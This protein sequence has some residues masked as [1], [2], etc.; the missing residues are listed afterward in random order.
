MLALLAAVDEGLGSAFV[1]IPDPTGLQRLLGIPE[2]VIPI[3]VA[4][5]G[6][7]AP[8]KKSP[9]LTRGR[10]TVDD[11][12]HLNGWQAGDTAAS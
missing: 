8:D 5:I 2:E 10:R 7:A 6:H 9:S 1:G 3:G 4:M 11:V 12:M